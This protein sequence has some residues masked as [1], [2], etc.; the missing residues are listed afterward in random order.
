[1]Q[2]NGAVSRL[3]LAGQL[4][5]VFLITLCC[6]NQRCLAWI[7][8]S[9]STNKTTRS[10]GDYR[11]DLKMFMK[12][13]KEA[14]P[15][16]ERNAVFNLCQLHF[17]IAGDSRFG[18]NQQLQGMRVVIAN[19]LETYVKD[20]KKSR[21]RQQRIDR[22]SRSRESVAANQEVSEQLPDHKNKLGEPFEGNSSSGRNQDADDVMYA[23]AAESYDSLGIISGG[24]NQ[25]F[26]YAGGQMGP[27]WDHGE[28]LVDLITSVIDPAF[29][30][31][32]G[33]TGSIHYYQPLRIIVVRAPQQSQQEVGDLLEAMRA[34]NGTQLNLGGI[35]GAI[36][37]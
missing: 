2:K 32:N 25:F 6:S 29:W 12:L 37:N 10:I 35:G 1:M 13:S 5:F 19:R 16:L 4:S 22:K 11:K 27:P 15:Q 26:G 24:P 8:Q 23:S 14:D 31:R 9:V 7:P 36:G 28:Q 20:V 30:R 17:E 21:L 34:A 3:G 33:G 18:T